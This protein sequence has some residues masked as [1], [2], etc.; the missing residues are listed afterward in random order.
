MAVAEVYMDK[1]ADWLKQS[2]SDSSTDNEDQRNGE[3]KQKKK[4]RK[5]KSSPIS[6]AIKRNEEVVNPVIKKLHELIIN[7][8]EGGVEELLMVNETSPV[9]DQSGSCRSTIN[10]TVNEQYKGSSAL[11]VAASCGHGNIVYM[12]LSHGANPSIK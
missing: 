4:K 8:D 5:N 2:N 7:G 10:E 6:S 9:V 3:K 12:L 11:H 1:V